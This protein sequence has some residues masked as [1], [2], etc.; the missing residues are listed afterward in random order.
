[1]CRLF[2]RYRT[3]R[4]ND[5]RGEKRWHSLL[6]FRALVWIVVV[7][8][9]DPALIDERAARRVEKG[10]VGGVAGTQLSD[11]AD[12]AGDRILMAFLARLGVVNGTQS[13]LDQID[14]FED[15]FIVFEI[16]RHRVDAILWRVTLR[17]EPVRLIVEAEIQS[18]GYR[19]LFAGVG[20]GNETIAGRVLL[21]GK[22]V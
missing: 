10:V 21:R 17:D 14:L 11:L 19:G 12:G 5:P 13:I 15:R 8:R 9:R 18:F 16:T 4:R 1:S 20:C 7:R 3:T 2:A 22:A 6:H